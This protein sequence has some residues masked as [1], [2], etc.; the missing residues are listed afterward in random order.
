M[1]KAL[2]KLVCKV[3]ILVRP[4]PDLPGWFPQPCSGLSHAP[5]WLDDPSERLSGSDEYQFGGFYIIYVR[6]SNLKSK[7]M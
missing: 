3:R 6:S 1:L 2:I 4:W 5:E 7:C